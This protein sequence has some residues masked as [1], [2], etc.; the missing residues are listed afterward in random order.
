MQFPRYTSRTKSDPRLALVGC[1]AIAESYYLPALAENPS[2]LS[3]LILVDRN[4]DRAHELAVK[5]KAAKFSED[6]HEILGRVDGVII[7][8]PTNLHYQ[9]TKDFILSGAPVL[10]EKPLA[11]TAANARDLV[12]TALQKKVA[13]AVNYLGRLIPSFAKVKEI[14]R[15]KS[16]GELLSI[17]YY[18][19]EL[20]EWP[21]V[22]GF[23]FNAPLSSRG[24]LRDRGAHAIDHICWWLN[25]KPKLISSKNDSLG[26]SDAVAHVVF[27]YGKCKGEVKLSWLASFPCVYEVTCENGR[28][29]GKVYDYRNIF[30]ESK[31]GRKRKIHL[32]TREKT[33]PL[34]AR[35]IVQN[36]IEVVGNQ[37]KPLINGSE[38]LDSMDFID[39][40]YA[41]ATR[42]DM[43]W[44]EGLR[45][46]RG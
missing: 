20:F 22:S 24:I 26:G 36:F 37:A 41:S 15:Q 29:E 7:A 2:I 6:Y 3:N 43:P 38:V 45:S 4:K 5:F 14:I 40:C 35:K 8:V 27:E 44:Y 16:L 34:V 25:G 19:G 13:L 46:C 17:C 18:V 28:I 23:Y 1:G 31:S 11:D 39:E 42:F 21:T 30:I 12:Q 32:R 9:I 10:C 33:K